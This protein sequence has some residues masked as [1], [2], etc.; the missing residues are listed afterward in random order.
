[1]RDIE[2]LGNN[3]ATKK[4]CEEAAKIQAKICL[5]GCKYCSKITSQPPSR[6]TGGKITAA[7]CSVRVQCGLEPHNMVRPPKNV[8]DAEHCP[9]RLTAERKA[10]AVIQRG[11]AA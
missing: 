5:G 2:V 6:S 1:M 3:I 10:A 4:A 8:A 7:A 11:K 9:I